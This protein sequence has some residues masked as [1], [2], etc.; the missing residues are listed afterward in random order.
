M[1]LALEASAI[2]TNKP[3]VTLR[4]ISV[5]DAGMPIHNVNQVTQHVHV[6]RG[7]HA[8]CES[9]PCIS[10]IG[11]PPA[12]SFGD[13]R[14]AFDCATKRFSSQSFQTHARTPATLSCQPLSNTTRR[15]GQC[16][17]SSISHRRRT[18]F[19]SSASTPHTHTQTPS[20]QFCF[21]SQ[22]KASWRCSKG[23]ETRCNAHHRLPSYGDD[24]RTRSARVQSLRR[25]GRCA[26]HV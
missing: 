18:Q 13:I 26:A 6:R 12:V 7:P 22:A 11:Y 8:E 15:T 9:G 16:T 23:P 19:L 10:R 4:L 5:T 3:C 14:K 20:L 1:A 24:M 17:Y 21:R 2:F 25:H